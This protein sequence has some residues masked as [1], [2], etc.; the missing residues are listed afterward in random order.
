[1][2]EHRLYSHV[3]KRVRFFGLHL[4]ELACVAGGLLGVFYF[5]DLI[6]K[7]LSLGTMAL[8]CV[9]IQRLRRV[10]NG[11]VERAQDL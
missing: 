4:E 3:G 9:N 1:M 6:W 2:R 8:V 5:Q 11:N 10:W 7:S